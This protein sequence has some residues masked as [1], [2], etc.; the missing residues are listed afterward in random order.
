MKLLSLAL[1]LALLAPPAL[2]QPEVWILDANDGPGTDFTTLAAAVDGTADGDILIIR[3]GLYFGSGPFFGDVI[4]E[5]GLTLVGEAGVSFSGGIEVNNLA[6]TQ[7]FALRNVTHSG[8]MLAE[9][10]AGALFFEQVGIEGEPSASTTAMMSVEN[11]AAVSVQRSNLAG[12]SSLGVFPG[13]TALTTTQTGLHLFDCNLYGGSGFF[14]PS[15]AGAAPGAPG[16][17]M[18]G[19]F[20]FASGVLFDGGVFSDYDAYQDGTASESVLLDVEGTLTVAEGASSTLPGE[21]RSFSATAIAREGE[22]VTMNWSGPEGELAILN[23]STT[24][25]GLFYPPFHGS[26]VLG[27]PLTLIDAADF[28]PASGS[29]SLQVPVPELGAGVE[30]LAFFAQGSFANLTTSEIHLGGGSLIVLLDAL[31]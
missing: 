11:C 1:L 22:L 17:N 8:T 5:H 25:G 7:F 15:P 30:G 13:L 3:P 4:L 24:P 27:L 21:A 29:V 18:T 23:L 2:A 14:H 12:Q 28:L 9:D 6:A 19:G 16:L 20:L 26:G 10:N 31:L